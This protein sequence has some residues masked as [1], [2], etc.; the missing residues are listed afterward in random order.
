MLRIHKLFSGSTQAPF[1]GVLRYE[2][3]RKVTWEAPAAWA[4]VTAGLVVLLGV[5]SADKWVSSPCYAYSF[6]PCTQPACHQ[7]GGLSGR[8]LSP[9]LRLVF[10]VCC[11]IKG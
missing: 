8:C 4:G 2:T 6:R 1:S 9:A 5:C 10:A 3:H 7:P 11:G